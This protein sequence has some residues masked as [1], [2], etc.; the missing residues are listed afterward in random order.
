MGAFSRF[1]GWSASPRRALAVGV[2]VFDPARGV[3]AIL[4]HAAARFA[5]LVMV[6][7][8]ASVNLT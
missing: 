2:R 4:A 7:E 8:A 6:A 1:E 3:P 5:A